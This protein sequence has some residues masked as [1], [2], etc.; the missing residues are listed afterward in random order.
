[1]AE[2]EN[3]VDPQEIHEDEVKQMGRGEEGDK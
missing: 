2:N 3:Y 1:M